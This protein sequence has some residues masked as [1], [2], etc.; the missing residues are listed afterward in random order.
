MPGLPPMTPVKSSNIEAIGY[1][2]TE[3][4][5]RF[6]GGGLYTYAGVPSEVYHGLLSSE[7]PGG[8]FRSKV[9]GQFKHSQVDA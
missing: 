4:F 1:R 2:G 3:L 9:R 7:S 8:Y 6:K 5:V